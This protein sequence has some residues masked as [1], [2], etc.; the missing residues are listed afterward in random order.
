MMIIRR[1]PIP[2]FVKR[3]EAFDSDVIYFFDQEWKEV[4]NK[5]GAPFLAD[6]IV[7]GKELAY[8]L[9]R[10]DEL[11]KVTPTGVA[12]METPGSCEA[13]TATST[14]SLLVSIRN[15]GI[16]EYGQ[17]WLKKYSLPYSPTEPAHDSHLVE[18]HGQVAF[19]ITSKSV[20]YGDDVKFPGQTML[21]VTSGNE[22]KPV[23]LGQR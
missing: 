17:G 6:K 15:D 10:H 12:R 2:S 8:I 4:P 21:W 1:P 11:L 23:A 14:G 18:S 3:G 22:L 20:G 7:V 16:Y 9:T 13:I 19:A 5:V